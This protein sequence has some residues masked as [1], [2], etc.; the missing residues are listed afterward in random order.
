MSQALISKS[1][2]LPQKKVLLIEC[3][4]SAYLVDY[5]LH[6]K[7][8][9]SNPNPIREDKLRD[10]IACLA[11]HLSI[12]PP[13]ETVAFTLHMHS[14]EPF[15]LFATGC[16]RTNFIVGHVLQDNIRHTDINMFHSQTIKGNG[17]SNTSA[18]RCESDDIKE[19]FEAYYSKSE[20]LPA[21][22]F[23]IENSDKAVAIAAMPEYDHEWFAKIPNKFPAEEIAQLE[24]KPMRSYEFFFKCDCSPDKLLPYFKSLN[25]DEV[26]ELYGEDS[27]L[28]IGCPRCG[29]KFELERK[30]LD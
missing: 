12:R 8:N 29:R 22:A 23:F 5:F 13:E 27:A 16:A 1:V 15:S 2:Y 9:I 26:A 19:M 25:Q 28:I 6:L 30:L 10:L 21:R 14:E 3:D 24:Q 18:V 20:Q 17:Q 4:L 11:L 7:A